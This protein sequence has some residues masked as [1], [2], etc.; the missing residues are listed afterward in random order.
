MQFGRRLDPEL[1]DERA[2]QALEDL[3]RLR[4]PAAAIQREHQLAVQALP[5]RVLLDE[6][7]QLRDQHVGAP[8]GEIGIDAQLERGQ[9][10]L[11]QPRDLRLGEGAEREVGEGVTA[12]ERQRVAQDG[13]G[14]LRVGAQQRAAGFDA[15]GEAVGVELAGQH[16]QAIPGRRGGHELGVVA[17]RAAQARDVHAHRARRRRRC[18]LAEQ[19][20]R[21]PLGADRLVRAQQQNGEQFLQPATRHFH[22][23]GRSDDFKRTEYAE[24]HRCGD[25]NRHGRSA[26]A[27]GPN[28]DI[29]RV[30]QSL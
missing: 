13:R 4:L 9:A 6:P 29:S 18:L 2:A 1:V 28:A 10:E 15:F 22:N 8:G 11:P 19:G 25:A 14:S 7:V 24:L 27:G 16:A 3:E 20:V 17:E 30:L 12:P 5:Q 21:E 26:L 23:T